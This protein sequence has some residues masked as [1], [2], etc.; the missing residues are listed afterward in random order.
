MCYFLKKKIIFILVIFFNY[1]LLK[2]E[3]LF[4]LHSLFHLATPEKIISIIYHL[5]K[6]IQNFDQLFFPFTI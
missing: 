6:C 2:E 1:F 3:T 4:R 5:I